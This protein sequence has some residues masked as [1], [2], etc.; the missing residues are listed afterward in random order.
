MSST[1]ILGADLDVLVERW[2]MPVIRGVAAIVF[3]VLALAAPSI[4]LIAL[5]VMWGAY[6]IADG[7]FNVILAVRASRQGARIGS[8]VFQ[9]IA[10]IAAGVLTFVYPG[11][12]AL[13]LLFVIAGWAVVTGIIEIVTAIELRKFLRGEWM[14]ALA[15]VLSIAPGR[16][17]G[18]EI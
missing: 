18:P 2:W 1:N 10:G 12:T 3:G 4:G 8:Y 15:G 17:F 11:I 9:A 13:V 5:I 6:A 16:P 14:L 7:V